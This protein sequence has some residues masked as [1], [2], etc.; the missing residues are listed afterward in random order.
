MVV[1]CFP[2]AGSEAMRALRSP[3]LRNTVI[4]IGLVAATSAWLS[5]DSYAQRH[6]F[7]I[8]R[9]PSLPNWAYYFER[10]KSVKRGEVAFFAPPSNPLV[11]AHFGAEP[12]VFGKIVYG[13]PGDIV[14]HRGSDVVVSWAAGAGNDA[15]SEQLVGKLKPVS[16]AGEKLAPG[17]TGVIPSGCYYMGSPHPDGFDSRYAAIGFVCTRQIVGV[18]KWSLL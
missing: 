4:A 5:L 7:F 3:F 15:P 10:E 2:A 14:S 13:M 9:S 1:V 11:H 16:S 8:N 17:P 12:P 18:S 6:G